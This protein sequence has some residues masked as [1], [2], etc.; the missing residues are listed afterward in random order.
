MNHLAI[1]PSFSQGFVTHE[2][3]EFPFL[4]KRTVAAYAPFLGN[5]GK[6]LYDWSGLLKHGIISGAVWSS[7]PQGY[8]L[9][10]GGAHYV[11][12]GS[13]SYLSGATKASLEVWF[14][15]DLGQLQ[16]GIFGVWDPVNN[17]GFFLQSRITGDEGLLILAGNPL[18]WGQVS[19]STTSL[20]HAV[21]VFDGT[22]SGDA[23]RLKLIVNGEPQTLSF[24]S[25]IPAALGTIDDNVNFGRINGLGRF[26]DGDI[27]K[28]SIYLGRALTIEDARALF[29][30]PYSMFTQTPISTFYALSVTPIDLYQPHI[31]N[32]TP[33]H[34]MISL[35]PKRILK[36]VH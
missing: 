19:I 18:D 7:S 10:F 21:A 26:W 8:V 15:S 33:E 5:Q 24:N 36:W 22:L 4:W 12:C 35:K 29:Y 17:Q 30:N 32:L 28:G 6:K 13:G 25:S 27:G 14:R 23:N 3:S 31:K 9:S 20:T 1:R 34:Q 11:D 2:A 16:K